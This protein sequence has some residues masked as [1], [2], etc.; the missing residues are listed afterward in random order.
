MHAFI[1]NIFKQNLNLKII[2]SIVFI[3]LINR[4]FLKDFFPNNIF[5]VGYLND[6]LVMPLI[7]RIF[8]L[9]SIILNI[10]KFPKDKL[11]YY[12]LI[13]L[14]CS[15]CFELI[16]PILIRNSTFDF[17][18]IYCYGLGSAFDYLLKDKFKL[19]KT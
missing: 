8:Y 7:F 16:R 10:E 14:F 12:L 6:L 19:R 17:L 3:Y 18:D 13:F 1:K 2:F 4:F 11:L 15:F 5:I 9:S